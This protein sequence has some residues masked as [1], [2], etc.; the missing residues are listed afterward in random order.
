MDALS[1]D[2]SQQ[3]PVC[4]GCGRGDEEKSGSA[5]FLRLLEPA[6]TK[7]TRKKISEQADRR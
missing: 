4:G 7:N 3:Q 5:F 6:K 1:Q 2:R